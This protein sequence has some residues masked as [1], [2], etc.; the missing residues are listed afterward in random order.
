VNSDDFPLAYFITWT[1]YGT[2]LPGDE[3][4]WLMRGSSAIRAPDPALQSAAEAAMTEEPVVLTPAQR[5]LVTSVV[6]KHCQIRQW[7]LYAVNVR[8]NHVHVVVRAPIAGDEVRAQFKAWCSR[9]L[10]QQAG[11]LGH[12]KN[13]LRRWFTEKGDVRWIKD[14][15]YLADA[16]QYVEEFQ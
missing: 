5:D 2:W 10:S 14:E 16:I 6:R 1:T 15:S 4:G 13:G 3:R 12:G 8:S 11:L 7:T 9:R